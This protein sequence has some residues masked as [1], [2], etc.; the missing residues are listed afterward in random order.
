M[1]HMTF[2]MS[3]LELE[4]FLH[5]ILCASKYSQMAS[6]QQ[7]VQERELYLQTSDTSKQNIHFIPTGPAFRFWVQGVTLQNIQEEPQV[8]NMFS[9]V[10]TILNV[11]K[12]ILSPRSKLEKFWGTVFCPKFTLRILLFDSPT[13]L[14]AAS[15]SE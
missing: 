6:M 10:A 15:A 7:N 5:E 1:L 12:P 11:F 3:K 9:P 2:E 13:S 14:E 8:N 4:L